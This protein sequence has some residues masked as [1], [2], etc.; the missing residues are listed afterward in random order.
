M[1]GLTARACGIRR[2]GACVL[3]RY[4]FTAGCLLWFLPHLLA[5]G[6]GRWRPGQEVTRL[7]LCGEAGRRSKYREDRCSCRPPSG[8][9]RHPRRARGGCGAGP[10]APQRAVYRQ[11]SLASTHAR[12]G[13][14]TRAP[15]LIRAPDARAS[16][17]SPEIFHCRAGEAPESR[18]PSEVLSG[19]AARGPAQ[20]DRDRGRCRHQRGDNARGNLGSIRRDS[21]AATRGICIVPHAV[22]RGTQGDF[23]PRT[24]SHQPAQERLD[25]K[26]PVGQAPCSESLSQRVP[27]RGPAHGRSV[28]E[29]WPRR[30]FWLETGAP[31]WQLVAL[32][33]GQAG[34]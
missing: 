22:H 10:H 17:R 32:R 25:T 11:R 20:S 5:A 19:L 7:L 34:V 15:W 29:A 6:T 1:A 14:G 18:C 33:R 4:G 23:E 2:G 27:P 8:Q 9:E 26:G 21:L 28:M 24:L 13:L 30:G 12:R 16:C 3:A 31:G